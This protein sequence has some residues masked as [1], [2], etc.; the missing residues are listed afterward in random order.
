MK[1]IIACAI[2]MAAAQGADLDQRFDDYGQVSYGRSS[3]DQPSYGGR[4]TRSYNKKSAP[5]QSS[6]G[7]YGSQ[8]S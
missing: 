5:K 1:F 7:Q 3:Y 2:A 4:S 6:Y 8:K